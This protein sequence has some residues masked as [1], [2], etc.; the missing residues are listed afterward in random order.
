MSLDTSTTKNSEPIVIAGLAGLRERAG[1]KLGVSDWVDVTQENVSTFARLTGDE[2]W[3][4]VDPDRARTGPYG[5]TIQHG[6]LT[7]GMSTGLLWSVCTVSGFNVVLN[8][9]LNKVRF[10]APLKVG[11]RIRMHAELPEVTE[12]TGGAQAIYRVTFEVENEPKPCCVADLV[13]RYYT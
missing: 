9:G 7:L 1:T 6:F 11:A 13:F 10:P 2:Q 5:T 8:Y 4:H 3:I 12:V